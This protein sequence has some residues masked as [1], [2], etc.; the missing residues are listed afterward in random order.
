MDNDFNTARAIAQLFDAVKVLNKVVRALPGA[1][2]QQD[3]DVLHG[4]GRK[5]REL[6]GIMGL[7]VED[8]VAHTK[9]VQDKLLEKIDL[10]VETIERM[11]LERNVARRNK[12]WAKGDII[13]DDLLA[14]GVELKDGPEGTT[15]QVKQKSEA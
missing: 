14:M 8:P 2:S 9:A 3:L 7:L 6:A 4:T 12:D 11:I 13:R 1:P 15:W 5:I 10:D